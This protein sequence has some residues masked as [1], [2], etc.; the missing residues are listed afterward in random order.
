MVVL[1][2]M[3]MP[4]CAKGEHMSSCNCQRWAPRCLL[5]VGMHSHLTSYHVQLAFMSPI[6][7][8]KTLIHAA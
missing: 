2:K 3:S 1:S 7:A 5:K 6:T 4:V 8:A